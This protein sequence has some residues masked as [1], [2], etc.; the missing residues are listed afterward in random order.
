MTTKDKPGGPTRKSPAAK[1]SAK[2]GA[3]KGGAGVAATPADAP[4]VAGAKSETAESPRTEPKSPAKK[5]TTAPVSPAKAPTSAVITSAPSRPSV[6]SSADSVPPST[7]QA[8]KAAPKLAAKKPI[9]SVS[10]PKSDDTQK[11]PAKPAPTPAPKTATT[12]K[13]PVK[14]PDVAAKPAP[15]APEKPLPPLAE[16]GEIA[17][18]VSGEHRDPFAFLGMH[19]LGNSGALVVRAF[20]PD[21]DRVEVID[22]ADG[23]TVVTLDRLDD[24]GLFAGPIRGRKGP[25]AYRLRIVDTGGRRDVDDAYRFAPVVSAKDLTRFA[26]GA[27]SKSYD[28]LGAH[29]KTVDGT[30]GTVF[31]VWAPHASR[32][33]VVGDFNGWDGRCHGMRRRH[34]AGVWEIF[35]PGVGAGALYKF[36]V[37]AGSGALLADRPDPYAVAAEVS[38]GSASIVRSRTPY[39]WLDKAWM[40]RLAEKNGRSAPISIYQVHLASWRRKPE[41][42]N[43]YLTYAELADELVSYATWMGFTHVNLLPIADYPSEDPWGFRTTRPYAP[44]GRFGPAEDFALFVDRCHQAGLG[45]FL[46]WVPARFFETS[47]SLTAYDGEP[48]FEHS[49]PQRARHPRWGTLEYDLGRHE[50]ANFVRDNALY[51]L[52]RFHVDALRVD[53]LPAMLYLDYDRAPGEWTANEHGGNENLEAIA[54]LRHVNEVIRERHSGATTLTEDASGWPMVTRDT[55]AGGLGFGFKWNGGWVW[56]TLRFMGRRPIHRKYYHNELTN[57]PVFAFQED[58]VLALSH[59]DASCGM[60]GLI[61][62][63]HGDHWQRFAH[64]RVYLGLLYTQPGKKHLFMGDEFAQWDEWNPETSLDW[65]VANDP[66]NQGIQQLVRDLNLL[67]RSVPALHERDCDAE[68]FEWI[69]ANDADQS[70]VS[71]LRYGHDRRGFAVVICNFTPVVRN[72]YRAGVPEPGYYEEL[73]NSDAEKYGGGNV[74]NYGGLTAV[75]D[76]VHGRPYS[77]SLRVPPFATVVLRHVGDAPPPEPAPEE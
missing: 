75:H 8:E 14:K 28:V 48:L 25:F 72:D 44:T 21:A 9:K 41:E 26:E 12:V 71:F 60:G 15:K 74:G 50:V 38:P 22:A 42:N 73:L 45:V 66:S 33:A 56:D 13:E 29:P 6:A 40:S 37:R 18:V 58:F 63:M 2:P 10:T 3:V 59:K 53:A 70:I 23:K 5:A 55:H 67:Y 39:R 20:A 76:S 36:Q 52:E 62:R 64:L 69:D 47:G 68:G 61:A 32:V 1:P 43:R 17:A 54:F 27:L 51:W 31:A 34:E 65:H 35:I 19:A 77:L 30:K 49:D 7:L 16:A 4:L 57:G 46:D 11:P 24:A